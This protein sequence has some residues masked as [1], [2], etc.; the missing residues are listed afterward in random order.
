MESSV[1]NYPINNRKL[2]QV[3]L[4]FNCNSLQ[5]TKGKNP[6]QNQQKNTPK[7]ETTTRKPKP[8]ILS[9]IC[10]FTSWGSQLVL[11]SVKY[12]DENYVQNYSTA[13]QERKSE[14]HEVEPKAYNLQNQYCSSEKAIVRR[15]TS[16][17]I[18]I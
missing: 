13:S 8:K 15:L 5:K 11:S 17:F 10:K 16:R 9:H 4:T 14:K 6:K 2:R 3:C 1:C 12:I 7:K 18:L